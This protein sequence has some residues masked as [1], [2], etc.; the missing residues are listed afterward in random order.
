MREKHKVVSIIGGA[1]CTEEEVRIAERVGYLLGERGVVLVCGGRGGIMEGGLTVG[2]LPGNSPDEGNPYLDVTI[3]TG[4]GHM[5][6]Y[7]VAQ[8][9]VS[10]IAIGGGYGTLS[11][12]A[13]ALKSGRK[14]IGIDTWEAADHRGKSIEIIR[15]R[16]ADEAVFLALGD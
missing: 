6:N 15:A 12:I 14:V 3:P 10:V 1:H 4:L 8:A 2:I 13:I 9:A 7:L 11:E 5:R 16:N